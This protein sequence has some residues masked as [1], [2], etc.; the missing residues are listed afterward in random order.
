MQEQRLLSTREVAKILNLSVPM[1]HQ[2]RK[3]KRIKAVNVN[4]KTDPERLHT[5]FK[6]EDIERFICDNTN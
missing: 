2:L 5:R 4:T 1:V 6:P 3:N